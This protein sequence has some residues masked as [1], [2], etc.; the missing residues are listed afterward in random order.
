M[1]QTPKILI[2]D[3]DPIILESLCE[4]F[5]LEGYQAVGPPDGQRALDL[6][7]KGRF[8]LVISDVNMPGSDGFDLLRLIKKQFRELVVILIT[9]YGSISRAVEAIKLGAHDYLT[10]PIIDAEL[11]LVTDRALNQQ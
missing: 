5:R 4:F 8:N 2:V 11:S 7:D 10:K 1:S 9:G 3:D 6:L